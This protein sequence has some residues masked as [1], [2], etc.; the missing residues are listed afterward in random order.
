MRQTNRRGGP[1]SPSSLLL[2]LLG[3]LLS[4]LV[5]SPGHG[6]RL[7]EGSGGPDGGGVA[8]RHAAIPADAEADLRAVLDRAAFEANGTRNLL[9]TFADRRGSE[10]YLPVFLEGLAKLA[11]KHLLRHLVVIST[12]AQ[13]H[14]A[15]AQRHPLCLHYVPSEP[16]RLPRGVKPALRC[17]WARI[18]FARDALRLGY[19]VLVSDMDVMWMRDPF[20]HLLVSPEDIQVSM[21]VSWHYNIGIF[22]VR[23]GRE[24]VRVMDQWIQGEKA[25]S[26]RL[27]GDQIRFNSVIGRASKAGSVSV[28]QLDMAAFPNM[29]NPPVR[30]MINLKQ[31]HITPA[32]L[33]QKLDSSDW[34]EMHLACHRV[35]TMERKVAELEVVLAEAL[36]SRRRRGGHGREQAQL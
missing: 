35:G 30:D 25:F 31:R 21:D 3:A 28:R 12:D 1:R 24:T 14:A 36:R 11:G 2:I 4:L 18:R 16:M 26:L 20:P 9:V 33:A 29:C 17:G 13:G 8:G 15:C 23:A 34:F 6:Q 22:Y 27:G 5:P 10:N 32:K 19:S 7:G